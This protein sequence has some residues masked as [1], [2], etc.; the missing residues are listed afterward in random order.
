MFSKWKKGIK[1]GIVL[2][3]YENR[4]YYYEAKNGQKHGKKVNM[5]NDG[6]GCYYE[7]KNGKLHGKSISFN[8]F[9]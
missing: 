2:E 1:D 5:W 4:K 6:S 8:A 9:G 7:Y 3:E